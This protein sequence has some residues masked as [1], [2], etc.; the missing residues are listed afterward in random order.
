MKLI[1]P[2]NLKGFRDYLPKDQIIRARMLEKIKLV[3]ERFGFEPLET[4]VLEYEDVLTGK[5]GEEGEKL[6]YRFVDNG[7]RNVAMRY[8]LTVPLA[9]VVAQY[10]NDLPKPFKRYQVAPVF[11]AENTQ[12]G[13]YREFYQCDA[14]AVGVEVGIADAECVAMAEQIITELGIKNFK[15]QVSNRKLL[16]AI[17]LAANVVEDKIVFAIR[18]IDKMEKVGADEVSTELQEKAGMSADEAK[19]LIRLVSVK[20]SDLE[21][22]KNF[23][24]EN[25]SNQP[26]AQEGLVELSKVFSALYEMGS[27]KAEIDLSLARGLDYYTSTIFEAKITEKSK[28]GSF[29]SVA[30]GGRYDQLINMFTG[31]DVPAVGISI[32]IDRLFAAM[33]ELGLEVAQNVVDVLV[34]NLDNNLQN[35][36]LK[37][38]SSLRA[39]GIN[40]EMYYS[41]ADMKKQFAFAEA[42]SIPYAILLGED[43]MKNGEVTI[44]NL[45]NREQESVKQEQLVDK[46]KQLLN[47]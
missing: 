10:Q 16:N 21:G 5:Y 23:V 27:T 31:K 41:E 6:M 19:N 11:R 18:A 43:E 17:M 28:E 4:P 32:G 12:R 44:R 33:Q 45:K 39:A 3:F 30:G 35:E 14:D 1:E 15:I 26:L 13:R 40:S 20:I 36:Y 25:L 46:V 8:D 42:K 38:V 29:S 37:V 24:N 47:K 22:L 7:E 9:R 34:L 2:R